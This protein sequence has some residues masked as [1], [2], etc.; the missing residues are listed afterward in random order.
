MQKAGAFYATMMLTSLH[1]SY[2]KFFIGT[3]PF[4]GD[5]KSIVT[6]FRSKTKPEDL[7]W[8]ISRMRPQKNES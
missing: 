4:F 8:R 6:G 2:F 5:S 7:K 1:S 3:W